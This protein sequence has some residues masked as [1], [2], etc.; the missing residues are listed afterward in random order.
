MNGRKS[1]ALRKM[2]VRIAQEDKLDAGLVY[3]RLKK[4]AIKNKNL[5]VLS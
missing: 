2:A 1:K 5:V 3:S 4:I